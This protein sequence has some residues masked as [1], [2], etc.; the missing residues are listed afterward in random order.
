MSEQ[1][2]AS[3]FDY[4]ARPVTPQ[5]VIVGRRASS[6]G[7]QLRDFLSRNGIPYE[8]VEIDDTERVRA[9]V[10]ASHIGPDRLPICLLPDGSQLAAATVEAVA[11]G[12]GLVSPPLLAE[13]DL[14]IVGAG[15]AG[16][17]AAVYGASE[18]LRT[19]AVEAVARRAS[20]HDLDDRELP[21]LSPRHQRQRRPGLPRPALGRNRGSLTIGA[22]RQRGR[23][24]SP[25]G[26]RSRRPAGRGCV[27][28]RRAQ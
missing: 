21:R 5:V 4:D 17:A 25:R 13:Y 3:M 10:D 28:R 11:T 7:Y 20:G 18:G 22:D 8:W 15:P 6:A 14:A 26:P 19:V 2:S 27:L 23:V 1:T 9:L 16:L 24:A 12:L